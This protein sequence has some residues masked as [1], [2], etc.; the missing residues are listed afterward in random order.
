MFYIKKYWENDY[1]LGDTIQLPLWIGVPLL[2]LGIVLFSIVAG[3][4]V[5]FK[6][7]V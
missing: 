1:V 7:R 5:L 2:L 3:V 4:L 6:V